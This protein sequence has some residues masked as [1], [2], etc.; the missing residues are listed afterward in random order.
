MYNNNETIH[1]HKKGHLLLVLKYF[2]FSKNL[3]LQ[4]LRVI[5]DQQYLYFHLSNGVVY[6]VRLCCK[7]GFPFEGTSNCVL[8]A[9]GNAISVTRVWSIHK[10]TPHVGRRQ[11]TTSLPARPQYKGAPGNTSFIFFVFSYYFVWSVHSTGKNN[12]LP[13]LWRALA[14]RLRDVWIR[15]LVIWHL[16]THTNFASFVWVRSTH[17]ISSSGQS[18]CTVSFFLWKS[19]THTCPS[20]Q[21]RR[22]SHLLPAIQD[23]P[24][25]RHKGEWNC[26]VRRWIWPVS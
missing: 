24:L 22:G 25:L 14:R 26:G 13:L 18:A 9:M 11:P 15:V 12:F 21:G 4:L 1:C 19:S 16:M 3:S 5:F 6:F 2:Y 7:E 20:F 10:K 8:F 23:P 17:A